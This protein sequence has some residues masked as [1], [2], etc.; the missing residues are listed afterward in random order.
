MVTYYNLITHFRRSG[1]GNLL[2]KNGSCSFSAQQWGFR[3]G[4]NLHA[5]MWTNMVSR[6]EK[7]RKRCRGKS[8]KWAQQSVT[9]GV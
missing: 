6:H 4:D 7:I 5:D 8:I 9:N 1:E 3:T 2:L